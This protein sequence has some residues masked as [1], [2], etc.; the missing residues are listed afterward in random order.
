[1]VYLSS[2]GMAV[3]KNK[4]IAEQILTWENI[5]GRVLSEKN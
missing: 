5:Y 1:M 4:I 3:I 2:E